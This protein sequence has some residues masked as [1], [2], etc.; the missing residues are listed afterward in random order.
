M[1]LMK[2]FEMGMT[3]EEYIHSMSVNKEN[4]E[5]IYKGFQLPLEDEFIQ[6]VKEQNLK[7]IVLTEDWCGD[8]MVNIPVLLKLTE[9]LDMDVRLLLRDQNL[10]LMDQYLTNGTSRSIPIFIF[11]DENGHEVAVWGPRAPRIQKIVDDEVA[12]LPPKDHEDFPQK[13][14][15]MITRLTEQYVQNEEL[16]FEV[17]QSIK[18]KLMKGIFV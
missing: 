5:T 4:L 15:E 14:S 16:W 3:P 13:R 6:G 12:K 8:A 2:W 1:S 7:V 11:I 9:N 10:E 18:M 17:Y